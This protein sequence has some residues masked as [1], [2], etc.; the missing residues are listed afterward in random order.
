MGCHG[1]TK[2]EKDGAESWGLKGKGGGGG[3]GKYHTPHS[4]QPLF[5]Y[6]FEKLLRRN[7][8]QEV[9]VRAPKIKLMR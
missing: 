8:R 6:I 4:S 5:S 9:R 3:G 1:K 2:S 7:E